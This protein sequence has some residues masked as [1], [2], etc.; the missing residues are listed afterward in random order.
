M[1]YTVNVLRYKYRGV[2]MHIVVSGFLEEEMLGPTLRD[3]EELG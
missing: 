3:K 1:K 2:I